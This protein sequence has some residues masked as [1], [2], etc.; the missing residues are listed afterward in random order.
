MFTSRFTDATLIPSYFVIL[1]SLPAIVALIRKL[2][3]VDQETNRDHN[4]TLHQVKW[5]GLAT[6][7]SV[8]LVKSLV[9]VWYIGTA[10]GPSF[11]DFSGG[12]TFGSFS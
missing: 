8:M 10:Q 7:L 2:S 4:R 9:R 5:A 1:L 11:A 6:C 3:R 12:N